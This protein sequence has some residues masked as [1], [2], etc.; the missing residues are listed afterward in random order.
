[1][2]L[3]YLPG[4]ITAV[5]VAL[6][7]PQHAAV[8]DDNLVRIGGTGMSLALM[9]QMA[10]GFE[11][12]NPGLR[13]EVLPSL[14]TQGGLRALDLD[15]IDVAVAGRTL[16]PNERARGFHEAACMKTLIGFVSSHP[17]PPSLSTADLPTIYANPGPMW[18][19]GRPLKIILRTR[20]SWEIPYLA[21]SI[22]GMQPALEQAFGHSGVPIAVTD[23]ENAGLAMQVAGSFAIMSL[24]QLKA[25]GLPLRMLPLDGVAP[26]PHSLADGSYPLVTRF[27][28]VLSA[29]PKPA[30]VRFIEHLRSAA[31]EETARTLGAALSQ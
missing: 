18:P 24:V 12:A 11:A 22:S 1:M 20:E 29:E 19:D 17:N 4:F 3:S 9:R 27:C 5:F 16:K 15:M 21:R 26:T 2:G 28:A 14:G 23:Q 10:E 31:A 30:A 8:A 25:E 6:L 7:V 13:A